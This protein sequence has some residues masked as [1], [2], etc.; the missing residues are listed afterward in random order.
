MRIAIIGQKWLGAEVVKLAASFGKV[1]VAIGPEGD[2]MLREAAAMGGECFA[3]AALS[4][5]ASLPGGLDVILSAHATW[6]IPASVRA[7]ARYTIG[8]HPSLLP[9]RPGR[10]AVPETIAGGDR[11]TGGTLFHLDDGY[12]TGPVAFQ[13]WCFVPEGADAAGLWRE[14]LAPLGV[15]LF[16]KALAHLA[17]YDFIP[18]E[19]QPDLSATGASGNVEPM[20]A[21]RGVEGA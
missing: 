3:L 15:E 8:Y 14:A 5:P 17:A 1:V 13:D 21:L 19:R 4:E 2:R 9:L 16:E 20:R 7:L 11:V 6:R 18:A 12:D 10:H